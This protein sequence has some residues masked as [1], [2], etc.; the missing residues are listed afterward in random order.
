MK[1]WSIQA[2]SP[3][4]EVIIMH[5]CILVADDGDIYDVLAPFADYT[6]ESSGPAPT[7]DYF[8]VGGRFEGLL[9][10]KRPRQLRKFFGL[11]P[12]GHTTHVSVAQKSEVDQAALLSDPPA[13]LFFRGQ[14]YQSPY[15]AE[16]EALAKWHSEFRQRFAEIPEHTL[17]QIVDAHS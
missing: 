10:L 2:A 5:T 13:A 4:G 6:G 8:G 16:G 3:P 11:L 12:A 9:P 15:F 14:L 17:L 1:P 7:F